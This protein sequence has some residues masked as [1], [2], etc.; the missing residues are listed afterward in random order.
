M[1][2]V[3]SYSGHKINVFYINENSK[4]QIG[5][6]NLIDNLFVVDLLY[7]TNIFKF[8]TLSECI[9]LFENVGFILDGIK[10]VNMRVL[11]TRSENTLGDTFI[12]LNKD[13][14]FYWY[15]NDDYDRYHFNTYDFQTSFCSKED[16]DNFIKIYEKY[17]ELLVEKL[18]NKNA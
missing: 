2:T 14:L 4:F 13:L 7:E 10:K 3:N 1:I 11:E 9:S 6:I 16:L 12:Y 8:T 5:T 17:I 18:W 15:Y